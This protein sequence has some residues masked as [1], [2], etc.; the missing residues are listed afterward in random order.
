MK[1]LFL[2]ILVIDWLVIT[3]YRRWERNKRHYVHL[4]RL[5]ALNCG[6]SSLYFLLNKPDS[7][8]YFA[9]KVTYGKIITYISLLN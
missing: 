2:C 9:G 4:K 5:F 6:G 3:T 1:Q 8:S 7:C